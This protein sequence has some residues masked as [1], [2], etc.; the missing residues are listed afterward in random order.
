[1]NNYDLDQLYHNEQ[2]FLLIYIYNNCREFFYLEYVILLHLNHLVINSF[3]PF[4]LS[5]LTLQVLV[6]YMD[7]YQALVGIHNNH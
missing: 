5:N 3:I 6:N 2:Q 7:S 1:M 4:F